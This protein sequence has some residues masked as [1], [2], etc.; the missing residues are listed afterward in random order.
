VGDSRQHET[1]DP[2]VAHTIGI[3]DL[4]S[5]NTT[6]LVNLDISPKLWIISINTNMKRRIQLLF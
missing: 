4:V 5:S 1:L 3:E 6:L 2:I